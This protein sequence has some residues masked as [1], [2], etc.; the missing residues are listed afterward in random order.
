MT[1][2]YASPEQIK[3]E[4]LTPASDVYSL[5]VILYELAAGHSPYKFPSRAPFEVARVVCENAPQPI[6]AKSVAPGLNRIIFHALAKDP[7]DRFGSVGELL[8]NI[9]AFLNQKTTSAGSLQA[10]TAEKTPNLQTKNSRFD[11]PVNEIAATN[12]GRP[13]NKLSPRGK[14]I[15]QSVLLIMAGAVGTP[16]IF[17][18]SL[19]LKLSPS[20]TM[21]FLILTIFGGVMRLGYALL[22][23]ESEPEDEPR[24][25]DEA[26]IQIEGRQISQSD[27]R[28]I[29]GGSW[30]EDSAN[31]APPDDAFLQNKK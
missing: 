22:L 8:E 9:R 4:E 25:K 2:E 13:K 6:E 28:H 17:F 31:A 27:S 26:T 16:V 5:G 21:I 18:L 7:A 14:G 15:R 29:P 19:A 20:W 23:E 10:L 1:P 3:G 11:T 30:M 24:K 12:S